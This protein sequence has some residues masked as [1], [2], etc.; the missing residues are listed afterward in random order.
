MLPKPRQADRQG[1]EARQRVGLQ[2][3]DP[4]CGLRACFVAALQEQRRGVQ[5][6]DE[7]RERIDDKRALDC[8]VR[9]VEAVSRCE[10]ERYVSLRHREPGIDRQRPTEMRQRGLPLPLEEVRDERLRVMDLRERR[11]ERH[12]ARNRLHRGLPTFR[13]RM[14]AIGAEDRV[15]VCGPAYASVELRSSAV[16]CSKHATAACRLAGE[17]MCQKCRPLRYRS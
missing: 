3:Q 16:T 14:P 6:V 7:G 5:E 15:A 12:G 1:P 2:L 8:N 17:R 10:Q 4:P 9:L 13:R 11:V